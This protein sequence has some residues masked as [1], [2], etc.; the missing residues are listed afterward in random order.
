MP[1]I[2]TKIHESETLIAES[3]LTGERERMQLATWFFSAVAKVFPVFPEY[4]D[5][6]TGLSA[7]CNGL[8]TLATQITL[9]RAAN[10]GIPQ[11][12]A[13]G[14]ASQC[15]RGVASLM[16]SATSPQ[17]LEGQ[18]SAPGSITGQA[19]SRMRKRQLSDTL[20]PAL[21]MAITRARDY[22]SRPTFP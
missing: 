19:I 22:E 13:I 10:E 6:A 7:F 17:E 21:S 15:I 9:R 5:A 18:L 20:G 11:E 14:I 2:G 4:F 3:G 12:H 8:T 16:L 1:T